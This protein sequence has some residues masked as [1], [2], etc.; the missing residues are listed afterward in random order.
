MLGLDQWITIAQLGGFVF[1][2][3]VLLVIVKTLFDSWR[4]GDLVSRPIHDKIVADFAAQNEQLRA[5]LRHSTQLVG[6][7]SDAV[8]GLAKR[9][10][11]HD[12]DVRERMAAI[13]AAVDANHR[14]LLA[15]HGE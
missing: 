10:S 4:R 8:D 3:I 7:L 13:Q 1:S 14:T 5:D 11:D 12:I 15:R 9:L 6:K 2:S